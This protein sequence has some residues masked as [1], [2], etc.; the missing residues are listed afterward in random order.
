KTSLVV[1]P[2][3]TEN[4]DVSLVSPLFEAVIVTEPAV[5]PVTVSEAT[6]DEAVALPSPVTEPA[7][8]VCAKVTTVELSEVTML[9]FVSSTAAESVMVAPEPTLA[10]PEVKTSFVA[11]PGTKATEV[12]FDIAEP[13]S[14]PLIVAVPAVVDEVSTS[15]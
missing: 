2:T 15:E 9:L 14:L 10:G 8:A 13:L 12:P 11:D 3:V 1:A 6:P 7:P 4:V 5:W